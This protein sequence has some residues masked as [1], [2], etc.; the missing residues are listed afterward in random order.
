MSLDKENMNGESS[1]VASQFHEEDGRCRHDSQSDR[2]QMWSDLLNPV[3]QPI[4]QF[5]CL[6]F[7]PSFRFHNVQPQCGD[8]SALRG[9]Y[10]VASPL[11]VPGARTGEGVY[12]NCEGVSIELG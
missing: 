7:V 1:R 3:P 6:Q 9:T 2:H 11:T 12:A 10:R 8:N 4:S 5:V